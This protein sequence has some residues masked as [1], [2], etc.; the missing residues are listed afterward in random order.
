MFIYRNHVLKDKNKIYATRVIDLMT[1]LDKMALIQ[2][3][4]KKDY[5]DESN[6]K[7]KV[8]RITKKNMI[9][10]KKID[11]QSHLQSAAVQQD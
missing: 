6:L 7:R 9:E 10:I 2:I 3:D 1:R 8:I 4:K 5:I 11:K